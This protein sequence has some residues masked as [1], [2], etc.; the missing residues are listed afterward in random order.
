MKVEAEEVRRGHAHL[1]AILDQSGQL[2]ETQ[3]GDLSK[4]DRSR[5]SSVSIELMEWARDEEE[6]QDDSSTSSRCTD[7]EED[8]KSRDDSSMNE[9]EELSEER[10]ASISPSLH[11]SSQLLA[12]VRSSSSL[13][14]KDGHGNTVSSPIDIDMDDASSPSTQGIITPLNAYTLLGAADSKAVADETF[15]S[16]P[17]PIRADLVGIRPMDI[18]ASTTVPLDR[19]GESIE[20]SAMQS[21]PPAVEQMEVENS[22]HEDEDEDHIPAYFKPYAVAQVEWNPDNKI[23]LPVLLRGVL[24]PYQ[25]YGLEWLASLHSNNLNGILADEMGLG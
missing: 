20:P 25:F 3:H 7:A 8:E 9:A 2:L 19:D 22:I 1:D 6:E 4:A 23:V 12:C 21:L 17:F 13:P 5:S 16:D 11:D 18:K 15:M 14:L 10:A 24:R